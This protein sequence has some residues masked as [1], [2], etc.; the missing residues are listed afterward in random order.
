MGYYNFFSGLGVE[1]MNNCYQENKEILLEKSKQYYQNKKKCFL[2]EAGNKYR[3]ST[4]K[5][6][7]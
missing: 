6:I 5:I 1:K 2:E 4:K 3:E 7:K